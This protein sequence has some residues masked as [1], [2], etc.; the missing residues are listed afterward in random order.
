M[1]DIDDHGPSEDCKGCSNKMIG[2]IQAPH[3][4]QCR[5]R[6]EAILHAA[7][8]ER[9]WREQDR[10]IAQG[11]L[12]R[13]LVDPPPARIQETEDPESMEITGD[14]ERKNEK[15]DT[16]LVDGEIFRITANEEARENSKQE[17]G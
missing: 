4:E 6:F 11:D 1:K 14:E 13:E 17:M 3:T 16:M 15:D 7:G 9:V 12:R 8:D 10:L 5:T 2:D